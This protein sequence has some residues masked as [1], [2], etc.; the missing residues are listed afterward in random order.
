M[1]IKGELPVKAPNARDEEPGRERRLLYSLFLRVVRPG[2]TAKS[3]TAQVLKLLAAVL[4]Q[5]D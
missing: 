4:E 3:A 5:L 2:S 1:A